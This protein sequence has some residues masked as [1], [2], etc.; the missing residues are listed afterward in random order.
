M[1]MY[2]RACRDCSWVR[3]DCY[4]PLRA[5]FPCPQCGGETVRVWTARTAA[6]H[7]D[8]KFIGGLKLENLGHEEV[9]VY[10]RSELKREMDKRNLQHFTRHVGEQGSDKSKHTTR[11]V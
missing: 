6:I 7:G 1:P 3:D 5:D 10:S 4:E 8:D 11:W 9:T 2:D